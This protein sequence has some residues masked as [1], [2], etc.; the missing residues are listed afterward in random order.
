[1]KIKIQGVSIELGGKRLLENISINIRDGEQWAISGPSGSGKS[2][3]A[4]AIAGRIFF[5]GSIQ[6]RDHNNQYCNPKI[7]LVE[8]QHLFSNK[9]NVQQFYYQQ[10]F[11]ATEAEDTE[12]VEAV[13]NSLGIGVDKEWINFFEL[14]ALLGKPLIQLSNGE[15]K[16]LQLAKAMMQSPE[17]LILDNPF[18]GL[19]K[20]GRNSLQTALDK[21]SV[22]GTSILLIAAVDDLPKSISHVAII[23]HGRIS[24]CTSK[25]DLCMPLT[26]DKTFESL[27]SPTTIQERFKVPDTAFTVA[28]KMNDVTI[29]YNGN[30]ILS[31]I[32]W[33]VKKGERWCVS[34]PNGSG[35]STLLSLINADNPQ[36]YANDISLFD[37]R[38]GT[39]ESIWDIKKKIGYVSPELHL[40]FDRGATGFEAIASGLFDTIGLFRKPSRSETETIEAW[41]NCMMIS[42]IQEKRLHQMS[43]GEQRIVMLTRA[44]VKSPPMLV[45]D[46]PCQGLDREQTVKFNQVIDLICQSSQTTLVYVSHYERDIPSCIT[47]HYKLNAGKRIDA[48]I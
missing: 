37:Q 29:A 28:V 39:G 3:L 6:F 20:T 24:A 14:S 31:H 5:R 40:F 35:K 46:E 17:L 4:K 18:V 27:P 26:T 43:L 16:R 30:Q 33:T 2:L 38:R 10:R 8:Q 48:I 44:L 47:H 23:N 12:T 21:I 34:G 41:M 25:T 42:S 36:A 11:N 1:M 15:N 7:E 22:L 13:L 9:S 32:N 45:L 19:D